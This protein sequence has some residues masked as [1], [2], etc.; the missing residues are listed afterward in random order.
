MGCLSQIGVVI[1]AAGQGQRLRPHTLVKPKVMLEVAGKPI[2]GHIIDRLKGLNPAV[3]C[4][5]VPPQ[6]TT[7]KDYLQVSFSERFQFV[8]QPEPK[9]LADAVLY[10]EAVVGR[11]PM[12]V[13]LGDTIID[14]NLE[15][16]L[17]EENAIGVK[18]VADPRRFGVVKL[19]NGFVKE[20][21]E[22]PLQPVS[23]LAIVGVYFFSES[24]PVFAALHR[25]R[26]EKR[27]VKNEFQFTDALQILVDAGRKIKTIEIANWFDCGTPEALIDT[28]RVL[29]TAIGGGCPREPGEQVQVIPPVAI[30]PNVVIEKS[31][32]G[33]FVS[34]SKGARIV[35]SVVSDAL[36]YQN[37]VIE[38]AVVTQGI[39]GEGAQLCGKG[40]LVNI[41]PGEKV[42]L[43]EDVAV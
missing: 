13:L 26:A 28:N 25:L 31:V 22:K 18:E 40:A 4:V 29:L 8:V 19:E 24:A 5:V 2:I 38:K 37:A 15:A 27:M 30:A 14:A 34:V 7:I 35:N 12:L 23:N 1:P 11:L 21:V 43:G 41:G 9:G 16:L 36:V 6:D 3:I 42:V 39:V 32:I 20:V 17:K 33:P 10:A